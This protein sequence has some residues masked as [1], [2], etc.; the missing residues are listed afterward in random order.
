MDFLTV[1]RLER[2]IAR[3]VRAASD[4]R[5]VAFP[6]RRAVAP[7]RRREAGAACVIA[8]SDVRKAS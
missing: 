4:V 6:L 2:V 7:S 5:I 1:R 8:L 3:V